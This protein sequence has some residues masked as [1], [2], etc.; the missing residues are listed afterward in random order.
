MADW[1]ALKVTKSLYQRSNELNK[2]I[3]HEAEEMQNSLRTAQNSLSLIDK[4]SRQTVSHTEYLAK[5]IKEG[6]EIAENYIAKAD[7]TKKIEDEIN[8]YIMSFL[9]SN[10]QILLSDFEI[11]QKL[12]HPTIESPDLNM[13]MSAAIKQ[14]PIT[15][16]QHHIEYW[17]K[18]AEDFE[19]FDEQFDKAEKLLSETK[20]IIDKATK[21]PVA[22]EQV[23]NLMSNNVKIPSS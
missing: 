4:L 13:D 1:H 18:I 10:P 15:S 19:T 2:A 3:D 6:R 17:D 8:S 14:S 20:R 5:E 12:P 16:L 11:K 23:T 7:R 21:A 22:K 9:H